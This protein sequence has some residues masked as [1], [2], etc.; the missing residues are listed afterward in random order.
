ME[1]IAAAL[2]AAIAKMAEPA[3]KDA[4]EG[5]KALIKRRFQGNAQIE[6]ALTGIEEDPETWSKPLDQAL[7]KANAASDQEIVEA[8]QKLQQTLQNVGVSINVSGNQQRGS[9]N[10]QQNI[11]QMTGGKVIGKQSDANEEDK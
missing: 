7:Q 5:L 1:I 3:V 10:V 11:G 2:V 4:Y 9:H 8:A 6:G